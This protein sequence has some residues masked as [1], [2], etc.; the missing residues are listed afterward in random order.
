MDSD[1]LWELLI[2]I[3][4]DLMDKDIPHWSMLTKL[5]IKNFQKE[6]KKILQDIQVQCSDTPS[7]TITPSDT[8]L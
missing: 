7:D 3:S 6:Y 4:P 1:E 2:F 5:I 8:W